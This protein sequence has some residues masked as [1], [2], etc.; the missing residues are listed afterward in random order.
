M[1]GGTTPVIVAGEPATWRDYLGTVTDALGVEP[2]WTD[3][4]V[5]TGRLLTDRARGW[6]WAPRVGL[7]QALDELRRG[8]TTRPRQPPVLPGADAGRRGRL[9]AIVV[10]VWV[11]SRGRA[12]PP[13]T[14]ADPLTGRR[15][16]LDHPQPLVGCLRAVSAMDVAAELRESISRICGV[17][18]ES[19]SDDATLEDLGFDSLAAAEVLT[20]IEIRLDRS[21]RSTGCGG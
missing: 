17:P 15:R 6:G 5:W 7:A 16:G 4:P 9:A 10:R 14:R 3:E 11:R 12:P 13:W 21:F 1:A 20:D 18:A 19:I 2:E 8:L